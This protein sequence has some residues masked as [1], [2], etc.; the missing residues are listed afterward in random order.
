MGGSILSKQVP[1]VRSS[2]MTCV[3]RS[4]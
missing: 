4:A 3:A 2:W 1:L